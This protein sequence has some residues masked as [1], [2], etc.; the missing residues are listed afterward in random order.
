[1]AFILLGLKKFE[2]KSITNLHDHEDMISRSSS[3]IE[4]IPHKRTMKNLS[5]ITAR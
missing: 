3:K 2:A 4:N 1:M 5:A